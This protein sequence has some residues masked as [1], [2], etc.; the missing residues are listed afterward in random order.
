MLYGICHNGV[1]L[2]PDLSEQIA[3]YIYYNKGV[4]EHQK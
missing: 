1:Y 4:N 2:L 3:T